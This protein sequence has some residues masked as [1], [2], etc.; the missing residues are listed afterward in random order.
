LRFGG[1]KMLQSKKSEKLFE[2][3][4]IPELGYVEIK[5]KYD[6]DETSLDC[7]AAIALHCK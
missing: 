2:K 5:K 1:G 4:P 7:S 6:K 3:I